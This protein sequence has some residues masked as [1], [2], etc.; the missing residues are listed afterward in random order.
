MNYPLLNLTL[1]RW[2]GIW[3]TPDVRTL[4]YVGDTNGGSNIWNQPIDGSPPIQVTNFKSDSIL[5]FSWSHDGK[6][7]V[8][9]RDVT[10]TDIV[11]IRDFR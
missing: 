7:S 1:D 10:T 4:S 5:N 2:T 6:Q 11:L 8:I 9:A 3:W